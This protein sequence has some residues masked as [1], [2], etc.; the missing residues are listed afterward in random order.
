MNNMKYFFVAIALFVSSA[1]FAQFSNTRPIKR[2]TSSASSWNAGDKG[3][4][5]GYKG[6]VEAGFTVGLGDY[7]EDRASFTTAHGC[8]F[9]SHFF[10]GIGAGFSYYTSADAISVPIFADFRGTILNGNIS[11]YV[12]IKAGYSILDVNG[13]FIAPSVGCRIGVGNNSAVTV[14]IGYEMQSAEYYW[15]GRK[16]CSGLAFKLGFDF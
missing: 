7:G 2:T 4:K 14:S 9:N 6:F 12:D 11:P 1:T 3:P 13:L 16:N 15:V 8:Q 5:N 10:A